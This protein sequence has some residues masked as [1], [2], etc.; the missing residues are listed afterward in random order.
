MWFSVWRRVL[1]NIS[2]PEG[3]THASDGVGEGEARFAI[4]CCGIRHAGSTQQIAGPQRYKALEAEQGGCCSR[5]CPVGPLPL[6]FHTEMGAG[7]CKGDFDLP[8]ADEESDD[9]GGLARAVGA[10]ECLRGPFAFGI[11]DEHPAD[12]LGRRSG[13]IPKRGVRG[14]LERLILF[15]AIPGGHGYCVPWRSWV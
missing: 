11:P 10:E 1:E 3:K 2:A 9:V 7:F 15:A 12:W 8:S 5:D 14:D 13:A 6:G 4:P